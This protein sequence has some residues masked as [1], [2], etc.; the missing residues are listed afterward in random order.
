MLHCPGVG[1]EHEV[2]GA[3][4]PPDGG[5]A[6]GATG[7]YTLAIHVRA[8]DALANNETR[9]L[10]SIESLTRSLAFADALGAELRARAGAALRVLVAIDVPMAQV[11]TILTQFGAARLLTTPL[12]LADTHGRPE[13]STGSR[14]PALTRRWRTWRLFGDAVDLGTKGQWK[15]P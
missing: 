15:H 9:A 1:A 5:E 2:G 4:A 12:A 14:S 7:A 11:A 3:S 6:G 8:G 13:R 10:K